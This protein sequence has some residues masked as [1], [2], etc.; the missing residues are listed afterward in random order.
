MRLL[1][2][3]NLAEICDNAKKGREYALLGNYDSSVVYYQ[4]V[5]QQIHRHCQSL[6]DPALKV[7][8]QQ[9][10]QEL[11]E[12]YEQVK[13]IMG[14]LES[15]KSEKPADVLAPQSEERPEDPAVWPPPTPAEHRN[16][17]A[18]KRP[19][20]AVKQQRK[21]SPGLQHRGAGP[22]GRGQANPKPDRPWIQRR[23]RH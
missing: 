6:R 7:K 18:V 3:M 21:E 13:G 12:E 1:L 2:S 17:V 22:G 15:F 10:R 23:P 11:T 14:T 19:S 20:S 9:V 4:G 8:W 5:I 16:P